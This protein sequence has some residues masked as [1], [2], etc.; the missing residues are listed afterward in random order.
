MTGLVVVSPAQIEGRVKA[1]GP[2]EILG[3]LPVGRIVQ[4][5][6]GLDEDTA[7]AVQRADAQAVQTTPALATDSLRL[8][9]FQ[10]A[11][12]LFEMVLGQRTARRLFV[13]PFCLCGGADTSTTQI[14]IRLFLCSGTRSWSFRLT[15]S[16]VFGVQPEHLVGSHASMLPNQ[17]TR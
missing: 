14:E 16:A 17:N 4:D 5:G 3:P 8:Q 9:I 1:Y 13:I 11:S 7:R 12:N 2:V 10:R 6:A 15:S